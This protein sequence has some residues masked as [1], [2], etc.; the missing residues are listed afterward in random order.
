MA[1]HSLTLVNRSNMQL[2]GI[3]NVNTFDEDEIIL[4]T[5]LGYLCILGQELHVSMLSLEQGKVALE[6]KVNSVEYRAQGT[7]IKAKGKNILNRLLK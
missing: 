5:E 4:E 3:K 7:D 2:S 1:D 6:G